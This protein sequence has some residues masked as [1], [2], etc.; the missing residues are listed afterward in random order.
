MS[1]E[2]DVGLVPAGTA[3]GRSCPPA[4]EHGDYGR[5][6]ADR[7]LSPDNPQP[8][9]ELAAS[10]SSLRMLNSYRL[11]VALVLLVGF[12][13]GPSGMDF[14]QVM[15]AGF[16]AISALYIVAGLAFALMLYLRRPTLTTQ[17]H[18]QLY[19]DILL[20]AAAAYASGGV[21]SGLA[22]LMVVPVAGAGM[23]LP[24]RH[25]LLFAALATLLLLGGELARELD[26]GSG[27]GHYTQAALLGAALFVSAGLAAVVARRGAVSAE[28]A[29]RRGH[30]VRRLSA[31]NER[32]IQQ[33][34]AGILVVD[35][36]DRIVLTNASAYQLLNHPPDLEGE[37]L[38]TAAP[39]LARALTAWRGDPG[40][41]L[42]PVTAHDTTDHG[43]PR[44]QVQFTHLGD[45]G[46]LIS[47]EDAAF[48]EE[49][50]QQLK[51]ASLGRLTA[52]IAHEVRNPLGAISHASQLLAE[53]P[54]LGPDDRRFTHII[55]DHC[56]RVNNI[57][58]N[59]LALSRRRH[60]APET[61][62]LRDWLR[63]FTDEFRTE[64]ALDE[65]RLSLEGMDRDARVLFDS[66]HLHQVLSNLC[67]NALQHG[68]RDDGVAVR[69]RILLSWN[70][71]GEPVIDV[72]DNGEP[73]DVER[74]EGMFEPFYST[75]HGGTGLGLF[76]AR[77]LCEANRARLR[78]QRHES[79]N[80][81]R[82]T[83]QQASEEAPAAG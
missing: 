63:R 29:E 42:G 72:T 30:D 65:T 31:L 2:K 59:V 81:F 55:L 56:H 12:M 68:R 78:Y 14:G 21:I 51:L 70:D 60:G 4:D 71:A 76:L 50:L 26:Y 10:W 3:S 69:V 61:C 13:A 41:A 47:L 52:S 79:G 1:L 37:S 28:I 80:C 36:G 45:L 9:R 73:I 39:G 40:I 83:L 5:M 6:S 49:Q 25:A 32:I 11:F 27:A 15:P 34:E 38:A 17:A 54:R 64:R 18:V 44:L 35:P 22:V 53:S 33:M 7:N 48:I 62:R 20:L 77:E 46:I 43:G 16:Y 23:M 82:I 58:E 24:A 74:V 19:T 8:D 75:R 57:V 66:G 67:D